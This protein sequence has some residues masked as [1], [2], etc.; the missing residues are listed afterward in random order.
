MS[1]VDSA[2]PLAVG[3]V[4][5]GTIAR[6]VHLPLLA[7]SPQTAVAAV[8]DLD[9]ARAAQVAAAYGARAL[10]TAELLADERV[11][12]VL[13]TTPGDHPTLVEAALRA[14]KHVLAEKPLAL[15]ADDA[16]RLGAL[17]ADAGLV[18]QVGYMK[19]HDAALPALR[20]ALEEVGEARVVQVRVRHPTDAPQLAHLRPAGPPPQLDEAALASVAASDA[21]DA[22]AVRRAVGEVPEPWQRLYRQVLCGSVL[23]ELALL[24][25]TG[26]GLPRVTSARL[27]A[28]DGGQPPVLLVSGELPGGAALELVW[29]WLPDFP[30]YQEVLEVS[31]TA[32]SVRLDV[33]A[34]YAVDAPSALEVLSHRPGGGAALR[35]EVLGRDGAFQRQL[36]GFVASVRAGAP[37]TGTAAE[38]AA[39]ARWLAD[40]FALLVAELPA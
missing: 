23:H 40:L 13:V 24:R 3:V 10:T 2:A 26:L 29:A 21:A 12:A 36:E 8:S 20:A 4:G 1:P 25:A 19:A 7:R 30:E 31:A 11:E 22:A 18:L 14:G 39:D 33:A 32:G 38:A 5:T 9:A 27:T 37:V 28:W 6:A 15:A 16:E 35:R 34:P 17:A